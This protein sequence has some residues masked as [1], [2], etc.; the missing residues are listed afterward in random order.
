VQAHPQGPSAPSAASIPSPPA[1]VRFNAR[2]KPG[3]R[4]SNALH[5]SFASD[6]ASAVSQ[7]CT[8]THLKVFLVLVVACKPKLARSAIS[9]ANLG[10]PNPV[11]KSSCATRRRLVSSG[12]AG[13]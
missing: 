4:I 9:P 10:S 8:S 1:S 2:T 12:E 7:G 5:L 6:Q 11:P 13:L 3:F